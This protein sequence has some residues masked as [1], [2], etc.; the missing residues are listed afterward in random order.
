MGYVY[1]GSLAS[2]DWMQFTDDTALVMSLELD[3]QCLCNAF[4]KWSTWT[5]LIIKVSKCHLFCMKKV[6]TDIVQY[7]PY[8]I[9]NKTPIQQ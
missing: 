7:K 2:K 6:K 3:N 1:D 8:I 5:G 4:V 9:I